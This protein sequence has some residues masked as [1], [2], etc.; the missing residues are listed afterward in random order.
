[1][2]PFKL[3]RIDNRLWRTACTTDLWC[4]HFELA[5]LRLIGATY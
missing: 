3:A 1:M 5:Q 2:A 4:G